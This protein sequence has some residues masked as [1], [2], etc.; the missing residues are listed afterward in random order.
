VQSH[1]QSGASQ[2]PERPKLLLSGLDSFY[3]SLYFDLRRSRLDFEELSYQRERLRQARRSEFGEVELGTERLALMPYGKHPYAYVLSNDAFEIRL[4]ENISPSCH[5]QFS[6]RFLWQC[7]IDD[8]LKR[9]LCWCESQNLSMRLPEVVSRA[10]WAFDYQ[11][12]AI[13]FSAD[14]FVSRLRKDAIY[15]QN[16]AVQTFTRGRGDIVVRVYNKVAEI[17]EQSQKFWFF[18]LWGCREGVWRIEFQV[19]R[20]RLQLAGIQTIDDLR[21]LQNDLLR[22][23]ATQHTTLRRPN[24]DSNRTRWPLHSLWESLVANIARLPQSG[25][26]RDISPKADLGLRVFHQGRALYGS[27]KGFAALLTEAEEHLTPISF[28]D[29]LQALPSALAS[30]HSAILW[31]ADVRKRLDALRLGQW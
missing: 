19:R 26:V 11:I 1:S 7:G 12:P 2:D 28:H 25:L 31:Q 8:L 27:L 9:F 30:H 6:S 5:V 4:G 10:D 13:D 29:L 3:V 18:D 23:L 20:P 17:E 21:A 22:E 24:G 14:D 16:G 15:R